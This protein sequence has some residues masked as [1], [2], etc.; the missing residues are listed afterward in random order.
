[1]CK[2]SFAINP[3]LLL[4]Y[5]DAKIQILSV[6]SWKPALAAVRQ[7]SNF[8]IFKSTLFEVKLLITCGGKLTDST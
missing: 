5:Y 6:F 4:E 3:P 1:M 7:N 2:D 8:L